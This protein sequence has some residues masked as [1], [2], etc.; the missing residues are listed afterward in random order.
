MVQSTTRRNHLFSK[1]GHC[2]WTKAISH[3]PRSPRMIRFPCKYQQT[4]WFQPWF[5][6]GAKWISSIYSM[7]S[8]KGIPF[9][10]I[11]RGSKYLLGRYSDPV[12]LS[13]SHPH[14]VPRDPLGMFLADRVSPDPGARA[15]RPRGQGPTDAMGSR[16]TRSRVGGA[17]RVLVRV[18]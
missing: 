9:Q 7:V 14:E 4:S 10:L 2:G 3:H 15:E 5:Q 11:P 12:F 16:R 18:A 8:F 17:P 13:K 6:C 1:K